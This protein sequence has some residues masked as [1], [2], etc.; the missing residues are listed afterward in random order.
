MAEKTAEIIDGEGVFII[1][2]GTPVFI[3]TEA[4]ASMIGTSKQ[5]VG[6]LISD[7]VIQKAQTTKGTAYFDLVP[8]MQSYIASLEDRIDKKTASDKET[9]SE[10]KKAEA[11]LK[12]A[13]AAIATM[14]AQERAG[15]MHRSEDVAAMTEDLIYTIRGGLLALPGRLAVDVAS[16]NTAAEASDIIRTEVYKLMSELSNYKYD[17]EKYKERVRERLKLETVNDDGEEE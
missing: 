12:K 1:K 6:K 9:E 5:W 4:F 17:P 3:K 11:S 15:M 13:K 10:R 16:A 8:T 14:D 7:G 2:S